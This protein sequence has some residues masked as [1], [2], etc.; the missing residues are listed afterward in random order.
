MGADPYKT[1]YSILHEYKIHNCEVLFREDATV[2]QFID[3]IEGN[4]KY[5][6]CLYVYNKI[7]T[8]TIEEVDSL[9]RLEYSMVISV[10]MSLNLDRLLAK[11]RAAAVR[12]R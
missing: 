3:I 8:V 10:H 5:V 11:V 7:D 6:P 1:C 12:R 2:D 4:R 9:A